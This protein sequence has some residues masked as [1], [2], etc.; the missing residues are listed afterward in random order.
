MGTLR[1]AICDDEPVALNHITQIVKME[2]QMNGVHIDIE[3]FSEPDVMAERL[4][5]EPQFNL[6]F[7]DIDMPHLNGIELA[8]IANKLKPAPY[9][10]FITSKEEYVFQSFKVHPFRFLRKNDFAKEIHS[11][12]QDFIN[13]LPENVTQNFINIS[14][15]HSMYRLNV[16]DIIYV[17]SIGKVLRIT[18]K[19][20]VL[21]IKY[22]LADIEELL[23]PYHFFRI[24]KS[25][26]VNGAYIFSIEPKEVKLTTGEALP[27]S[28]YRVQEIKQKFQEMILCTY[29]QI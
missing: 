25:Y 4:S 23:A 22:V 18:M 12:I 28:R 3:C 10:V 17:E 6:L 8:S 19:E 27:L 20:K 29:H 11:C 9:I 1:V 21:E 7:L 24:H 5:E 14:S 26:L 16:Q 13:E 2:F 15:Q